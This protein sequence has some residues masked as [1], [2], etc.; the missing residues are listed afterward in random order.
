ML[1]SKLG[2]WCYIVS[3]VAEPSC[4]FPKLSVDNTQQ[5]LGVFKSKMS[6]TGILETHSN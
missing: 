2:S 3:Q 5:K 6:I 1:Y 4:T